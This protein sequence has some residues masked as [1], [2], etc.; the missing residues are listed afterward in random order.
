MRPIHLLLLLTLGGA[1]F[2]AP[3]QADTCSDLALRFASGERFGMKLG[4]L[5]ELKICINTLLREKISATSSE[6]RGSTSPA[7]NA[8]EPP[9]Q[10]SRPQALPVLQDAE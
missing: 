3:A 5:D 4:E 10:T 1:C 8:A 6:A 9:A 7:G 2:S